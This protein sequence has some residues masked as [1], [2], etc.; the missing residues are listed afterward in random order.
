MRLCFDARTRRHCNPFFPSSGLLAD[1][2]SVVCTSTLLALMLPNAP[3]VGAAGGVELAA[4]RSPSLVAVALAVA[5]AVGV[6][7]FAT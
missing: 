3:P 4:D 6:V 7:S 1:R 5:L 2:R